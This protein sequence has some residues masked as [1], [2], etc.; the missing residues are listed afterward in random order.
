VLLRSLHLSNVRNYAKLELEPSAGLNVFVGRNAQ[1]K[2]NLLEAISLLGTGKSFRTSRERDLIRDGFEIAAISGEAQVRAGDVR[3]GCTITSTAR[4]TRKVYAVNGQSLRYAKFL[5]NLRVVTFVPADLQ[6]V[7]GAPGLRRAFLN[8]ALAQERR[9]Y[10]HELA[11]YQKAVTQKSALLRGG[12]EPDADLLAIYNETLIAAGTA[13]MLAREQLVRLLSVAAARVHAQWTGGAERL[14]IAYQPSV[15]FEAPTAES[16]GGAFAARLKAL[17]AQER[18][19][20]LSLAGP[21]RDDIDLQLDGR[22]LAAYG[23]QGQQRTAVLALKVAEYSVMHERSGEAPLLLLDDVLS[24]LDPVR[25]HAFVAGVGAFEQA[26][27]TATHIPDGLPP[28]RLYTI[29]EARIR[30]AA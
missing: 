25:A 19:R 23:S 10:Y 3:L 12:D 2:S 16:I 6:L 17:A 8:V 1:G 5:G 27:I 20:Q 30:E 18:A 11:R 4:G 15:P 28:A 29:E 7:G 14:E 21:H 9:T 24:E 22:S 26:F 13:I